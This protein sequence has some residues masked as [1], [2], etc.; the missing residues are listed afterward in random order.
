MKDNITPSKEAREAAGRIAKLLNGPCAG[1]ESAP[2]FDNIIQS[3]INQ[4][5]AELAKQAERLVESLSSA[6]Y[7]LLHVTAERDEL[8]RDKERLD[9]LEQYGAV[10]TLSNVPL[11]GR[12]AVWNSNRPSGPVHRDN[13]LRAAI[14]AALTNQEGQHGQ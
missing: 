5:V 11:G 4:S 13:S 14:D 8:R 2:S 7:D 9:W 12:W 1:D 3:A 6:N 10:D